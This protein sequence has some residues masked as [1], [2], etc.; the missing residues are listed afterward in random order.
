MTTHGGDLVASV[1]ADG[2]VDTLFTLSGGHIFPII[3]G[4]ARAGMRLVETRH[5]QTAV[6]GAEGLSKLTRDL[7]VAAVTAG[8][9]V[10]NSL[11]AI[12]SASLSGVPLVVLGGRAADLRWGSGALQELDHVPLVQSVAKLAA[13]VHDVSEIPVALHQAL[14]LALAPH[15]GPVFLDFPLET[16]FGSPPSEPRRPGVP[17][18]GSMPEADGDL[19]R[20]FTRRLAAAERPVLVAGSDVWWGRAEAALVAAAEAWQ[21]P[22]VTN[23]L[24]RGCLS[25]DHPLSAWRARSLLREAD[26][27]VVVGTPL[28]FRLGFGDFGGAE[29]VHLADSPEAAPPE[30]KVALQLVGDLAAT[31]GSLADAGGATEAHRSAW[32]ERVRATAARREASDRA[33]LEIDTEPIHPARLVAE[34]ARELDPDG[35]FVGD[36]GDCVSWAGRLVPSTRPGCWLD[37]GPYGCLG[38]GPG[39]LAAARLAHPD[40]QALLLA[41]DGAL[42]FSATDVETLARHRLG[43]AIVVANNGT[44][45]LELHSMR[46]LYQSEVATRLSPDIGYDRLSEALGGAGETVRRPS[47]L[48]P[49]I[50]R[51]LASTDV[52]YVLNVVCDPEVAYPRSTSLGI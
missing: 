37:P 48:G 22:T 39:Y 42:G 32:L 51:A 21:L 41:G 26:L 13:T 17:L 45:G 11:S 52:P 19:V 28:D 10:T 30:G 7:G 36:G 8:P 6:F 34:V 16:L 4:C 3:D 20:A 27:V 5:E 29:V 23:G 9:G 40:R 46:E 18:P 43:G 2:S 24:G 15:R 50:R 47:E 25:A 1:L 44:W 38:T 49:A 35:V 12:V 33:F 31:L 14:S